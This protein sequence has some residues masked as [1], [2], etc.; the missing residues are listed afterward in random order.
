MLKYSVLLV[1]LFSLLK[2]ADLHPLRPVYQLYDQHSV[3]STL[4]MICGEATAVVA[5]CFTPRVTCACMKGCLWGANS[6][7]RWYLSICIVLPLAI[8]AWSREGKNFDIDHSWGKRKEVLI[9]GRMKVFSNI[10]SWFV[11]RQLSRES[12][13]G[14]KETYFG[15]CTH[16]SN[17]IV[18]FSSLLIQEW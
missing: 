3:W 8:M 14:E 5:R 4:G 15:S 12:D 17:D 16:Q 10:F 2:I 9:F 6:P 13:R 11:Q 1:W 7:V 18:D